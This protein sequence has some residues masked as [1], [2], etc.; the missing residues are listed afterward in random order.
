MDGVV[1][2]SMTQHQRAWRRVFLMEGVHLEP[3]DI[4]RREGM[5]GL[6][7]LRDIFIEKKLPD[8]GDEKLHEMIRCKDNI[9]EGE[10]IA[11]YGDIIPVLDFLNNEKITLGLV[12]G[13]SSEVLS[14]ILPA[15]VKTMFSVIVTGD[16][17]ARGKP[18]PEPYARAL[19][20]LD[21]SPQGGL[22]VENSPMGI[23]SA[24]RAH[25]YCIALE[26]TL[27]AE[28]LDEADMILTGHEK[29]FD[30][31]RMQFSREQQVSR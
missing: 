30:Y 4:F 31:F 24:K 6:E 21:V 9:F 11:P 22:V 7:S 25:L 15:S 3:I 20:A 17:V 23:L 10:T 19:A 14:Q 13:S 2:D 28:Y 5:S 12:T 26:T 29:L 16:M 8:P 18:S 1:V 27:P